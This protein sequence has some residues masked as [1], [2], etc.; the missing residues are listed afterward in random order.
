M[1]KVNKDILTKTL[2]RHVRMPRL[3]KY[4]FI[5]AIPAI[6]HAAKLPRPTVEDWKRINRQTPRLVDV[7]PNGPIGFGTVQVFLAGGVP[8]VMLH[9]R[10]LG[11]L[12]L[13]VRTVN[14]CTL[15]EALEE[16][17]QSERRQKLRQRLQALDG[18]R[19]D[20]VIM[21]P[22]RAYQ[23]GL[24]STIAFLTGNLAPQGAVIKSTAID[25]SVLDTDGVYRKIGPIRVFTRE[26]D[27]MPQSRANA[28]SNGD[29]IASSAAPLRASRRNLSSPQ[30]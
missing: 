5:I 29:I 1:K 12:K 2:Q 19:P 13:N 28:K 17:E 25:P 9:L 4:K 22:T 7:M 30:R 3:W 10:E 14:G 27:A 18:I 15:G 21:N 6:A 26:P 20:E 8:E 23:R 11:L 24:T 16:W